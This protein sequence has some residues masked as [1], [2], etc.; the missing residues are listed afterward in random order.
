M[1][2]AA[3][4]KRRRMQFS[5]TRQK[6]KGRTSRPRT[7]REDHHFT[8]PYCHYFNVIVQIL[9]H[10][11][12]M[13]FFQEDWQHHPKH[14]GGRQPPKRSEEQG[15]PCKAAPP[16]WRQG[17][18]EEGWKQHHTKRRRANYYFTRI[19]F[20]L[21]SSYWFYSTY[22]LVFLFGWMTFY[23]GEGTHHRQHHPEGGG[24]QDHHPTGRDEKA[25]PR[26]RRSTTPNQ[27]W[28]VGPL[29]AAP[30]TRREERTATRHKWREKPPLYLTLDCSFPT[31]VASR[32]SLFLHFRCILKMLM[33]HFCFTFVAS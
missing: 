17:M 23:R 32:N 22:Y 15:A 4:P 5:T 28:N 11:H 27:D 6:G 21:F 14:G 8:S 18:R 31:F 19:S 26:K 30:H 9:L 10:F 16:I 33:F 24:G 3:P 20:A 13:S 1:E 29:Q 2:R 12:H 7:R 25:S